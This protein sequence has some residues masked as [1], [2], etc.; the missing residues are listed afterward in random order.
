MLPIHL[1]TWILGLSLRSD[2]MTIFVSCLDRPNEDLGRNQTAA[3]PAFLLLPVFQLRHC[4]I[5]MFWARTVLRHVF[6]L[7]RTR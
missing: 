1:L 3:S 2:W 7:V 6:N 5:L 4:F